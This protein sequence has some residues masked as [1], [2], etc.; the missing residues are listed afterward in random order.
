[1]AWTRPRG[2]VASE[3]TGGGAGVSVVADR[4]LTIGPPGQPD[5][6][7]TLNVPGL[8]LF[9]PDTAGQVTAFVA[10][11]KAGGFILSCDDCQAAD[12]P[13]G[14]PARLSGPSSRRGRRWRAGGR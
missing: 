7:F 3:K 1:M 13:A 5:V 2:R 14:A 11:G 10:Q 12:G 4:W 6:A 8:P 9:D